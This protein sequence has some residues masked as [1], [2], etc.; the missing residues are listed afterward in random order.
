MPR[1]AWSNHAGIVTGAASGIGEAIASR[2]ARAGAHVCLVDSDIDGL[3]AVESELVSEGA[4]VCTA[5]ADVRDETAIGDI[6]TEFTR[7]RHLAFVVA[8]AGITGE[9]TAEAVTRQS[10][11]EVLAVNLTGVWLTCRA[12]IPSLRSGG[13]GSIV[14]ISSIAGTTGLPGVASYAAA[15]GGVI[16]LAR[17]M[18]RDYADVNIRVNAVCPGPIATPLVEKAYAERG[19][20]LSEAG[21]SVPIGR[22]GD[23]GDVATLVQH[24]VGPDGTWMTGQAITVDGGMS[25]LIAGS[26]RR[27]R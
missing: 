21:E 15:K 5:A 13:G 27:R 12:A 3:K 24:L 18:A 25:A 20:A 11:D 9:G 14:M 6:V 16:A 7:Q 22:L 8:S 2:L 23:V 26:E 17:Q 1:R 10:W 19:I 4:N